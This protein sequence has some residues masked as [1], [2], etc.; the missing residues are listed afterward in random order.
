MPTTYQGIT[1]YNPGEA[2]VAS[3]YAVDGNDTSAYVGV[4]PEYQTYAN[5]T[6]RPL[7]AS[8]A[9]EPDATDDE[10]S[11]DDT[12]APSRSGGPTGPSVPSAPSL[13]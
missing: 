5:E 13:P 2:N 8:E 1:T 12:P 7:E 9:L 11:D 4:S 3:R 10:D 6:E